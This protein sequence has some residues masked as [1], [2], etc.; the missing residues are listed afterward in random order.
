M[1]HYERGTNILEERDKEL[2]SGSDGSDT[3]LLIPVVWMQRQG[4]L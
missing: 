1:L 2:Y 3:H 4:D